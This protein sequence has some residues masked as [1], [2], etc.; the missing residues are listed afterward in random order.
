[1]VLDCYFVAWP[2]A[3]LKQTVEAIWCCRFRRGRYHRLLLSNPAFFLFAATFAPVVHTNGGDAASKIILRLLR[4]GG[5]FAGHVADRHTPHEPIDIGIRLA[6][7]PEVLVVLA[8]RVAGRGQ[9]DR[10]SDA[11]RLVDIEC[12]LLLNDALAL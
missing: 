5:I 2:K 9:L 4:P 1:M 7:I 6:I 11:A 8:P 12:G 3:I 10:R